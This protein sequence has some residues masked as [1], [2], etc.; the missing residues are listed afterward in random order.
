MFHREDTLTYILENQYTL[1]PYG[2]DGDEDS[3][4]AEHG[5]DNEDNSDRDNDE[6]TSADNNEANDNGES[7]DSDNEVIFVKECMDGIDD[8]VQYIN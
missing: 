3:D 6:V 5:S 8:T 2:P 1:N 7:S 4:T